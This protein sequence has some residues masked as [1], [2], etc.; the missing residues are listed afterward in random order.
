[1]PQEYDDERAITQYTD[2]VD[3]GH[4]QWH[5]IRFGSFIVRCVAIHTVLATFWRIRRYRMVTGVVHR[6][7]GGGKS[8]H[9]NALLQS[10]FEQL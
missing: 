4:E 3:D 2:D 10:R 8:H 9:P 7:H 5:D 6:W 1:M